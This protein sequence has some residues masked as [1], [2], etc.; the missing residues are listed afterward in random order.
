MGQQRKASRQIRRILQKGEEVGKSSH[1]VEEANGLLTKSQL[2]RRAPLGEVT[3]GMELRKM[4]TATFFCSRQR[5]RVQCHQQTKFGSTA[6]GRT[7]SLADGGAGAVKA[8]PDASG[9]ESPLSDVYK[10]Q[11]RESVSAPR[12]SYGDWPRRTPDPSNNG[13]KDEVRRWSAKPQ[14]DRDCDAEGQ[15]ASVSHLQQ[16]TSQRAYSPT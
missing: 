16:V 8:S 11:R 7:D 1:L 5:A 6:R 3:R 9:T 13:V 4:F 2:T 15:M 14:A 10:S 12:R